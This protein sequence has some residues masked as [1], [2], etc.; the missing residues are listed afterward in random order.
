MIMTSPSIESLAKALAAAQG[1]FEAVPKKA[2]NPFFK[3][4]YADLAAV[5][6]AA[7]PILAKHGLSVV[8]MPGVAQ[9]GDEVDDTLT[10]RL[11]HSSGEWVQSTMRMFLTKQD[12]QGQ[13]SAITYARRYAYSA[14]LGIVTEVDDDGNAASKAKDEPKGTTRR[15]APARPA[16]GAELITD[17]QLKMIA[18]LFTQKGFTERSV[19]HAHVEEVIGHEFEST[20]SLTKAEASKVIDGLLVEPDSGAGHEP[21]S[22]PASHQDPPLDAEGAFAPDFAELREK[23]A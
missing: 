11:M 10:T 1:D 22:S 4:K 18:T 12:P 15:A 3:S 9:F 21:A 7:S 6:R 2:E 17:K 20:K 19:C 8:Q 23:L 13:G 5:V 14:A 16:G